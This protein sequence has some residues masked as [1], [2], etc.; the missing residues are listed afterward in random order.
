MISPWFS[1]T[2]L[3]KSLNFSR[4]Y[5][6]NLFKKEREVANGAHIA[7]LN[8]QDHKAIEWKEMDQ[9]EYP[10]KLA[11]SCMTHDSGGRQSELWNDDRS[12]SVGTRKEPT[13]S[14]CRVISAK[15]EKNII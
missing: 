15:T 2:S 13:C 12:D 14:I 8:Q 1:C 3:A 11:N 6:L 7:L 5:I 10:G 9:W 4:F